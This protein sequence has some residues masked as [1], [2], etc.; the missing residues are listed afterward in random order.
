[1]IP[2][3]IAFG[4]GP[5]HRLLALADG[6]LYE[7]TEPKHPDPAKWQEIPVPGFVKAFAVSPPGQIVVLLH[8]GSLHERVAGGAPWRG[9]ATYEWRPIAGP[10]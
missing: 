2:T 7:R 1:M 5:F 8:D 6:H 10:T 3:H 4:A 9:Q